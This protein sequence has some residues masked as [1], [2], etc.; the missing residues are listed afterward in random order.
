MKG[1]LEKYLSKFFIQQWTIGIA[2]ADMRE[3]VRAK[4][5]NPD[6]KWLAVGEKHKFY[7]DP[8]L[9]KRDDGGYSILLEDYS[10]NDEYGK[11]SVIDYTENASLNTSKVILDT[12]SHLSYP[13]IFRENGKYYV[14]P[15]A[16]QSGKLS[17]YEY[18]AEKRELSFVQDVINLPLLDSTIVKYKNKYWLFG[19]LL[20]ADA[21]SK[22]HIFYA[23]QLLGPYT[24][25]QGNPVKSGIDSARPAGNIMEIDGVLYRPAQNSTYTYGGS[26]VLNKITVLSEKEFVEEFYMI[27]QV[28]KKNNCNRGMH[29]MH[30]IN[31]IEDTIVVDGTRWVFSPALK[32]K[33]WGMKS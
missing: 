27:L 29:A 30:T 31:Y 6:I 3:I 18:D 5:F 22:L 10:F 16:A 32:W 28:D 9:L 13:F 8:F 20:G 23:D 7:A 33:Q 26:M 25:H 4:N 24:A 15:E 17:C 11:L 2:K 19:T 21:D 14:F 12:K 1:F